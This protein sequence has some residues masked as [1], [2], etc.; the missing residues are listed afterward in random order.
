MKTLQPAETYKRKPK[1]LKGLGYFP[2]RGEINMNQIEDN[3]LALARAVVKQGGKALLIDSDNQ[4]KG[5]VPIEDAVSSGMAFAVDPRT[6]VV[7]LDLDS[8]E[9]VTE[10]LKV[11]DWAESLLGAGTVLTA[12]GREEHR[13]L[14]VI[15]PEEMSEE[16]FREALGANYPGIPGDAVRHTQA[17]RPPLSPHRWGL[18]V[19]LIDPPTVA[20]ALS[21]LSPNGTPSEKE[22]AKQLPPKFARLMREGDT[23]GKRD[24]RHGAE[25]AIAIAAVVTGFSRDWYVG[26]SLDPTNR[27]F[28]KTQEIEYLKGH[29]AAIDH[30]GRTYDKA[31]LYVKENNVTLGFDSEKFSQSIAAYRAAVEAATFKKAT[32]R[33]VL[34]ALIGLGEEHESYSPMA[35]IRELHLR[36][37]RSKGTISAA[38]KR[39]VDQGWITRDKAVEKT[40]SYRFNLGKCDRTSTYST[41]GGTETVCTKNVTHPVFTSPKALGGRASEIW[42]KMPREHVSMAE[43]VKLTGLKSHQ[44]RRALK[45]LTDFELAEVEKGTGPK[46][47]DR[48][49]CLDVSREHLDGI[50]EE[51]G[52]AEDH[53]LKEERVNRE[54][55]AYKALGSTRSPLTQGR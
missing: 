41:H 39:L 2:A 40:A 14:W 47:G 26:E 54:R 43:A 1:T 9:L 15:L 42:A 7:A 17:T 12:S 25:M 33:D 35:A 45:T 13:H 52:L 24:T 23:E 32:D 28:A 21:R 38:L 53:R 22:E 46:G 20:E 37:G 30:A 55:D 44:L 16:D 3:V 49:R 50:A 51:L 34:L 6:G 10:G 18:P 4:P 29:R 27:G 36:S 19:S 5:W 48:Y 8:P 31:V 11:K